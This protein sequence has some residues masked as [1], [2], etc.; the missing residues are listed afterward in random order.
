MKMYGRVVD[1]FTSLAIVD[2]KITLMAPD[3]TVVDSCS[4]QTWNRNAIHPEA[5]FFMTPKVIR[6]QIYHQGGKSQ[7]RNHLLQS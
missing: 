5:Y 6:R 4:T 7:I 2:S 1:S 3:S